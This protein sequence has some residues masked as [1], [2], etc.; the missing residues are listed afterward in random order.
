[1]AYINHEG[2]KQVATWLGMS[3]IAEVNYSAVTLEDLENED[4]KKVYCKY[5]DVAMYFLS[6]FFILMAVLVIR[7][8]R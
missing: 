1:M 2:G 7:R 3:E 6:I 8:S 4:L 5:L